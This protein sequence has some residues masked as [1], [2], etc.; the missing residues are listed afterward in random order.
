MIVF[1]MH[2]TYLD[3]ADFKLHIAKKPKRGTLLRLR[4][5]TSE[6]SSLSRTPLPCR[7]IQSAILHIES[8]F[9]SNK[10]P[11]PLRPCDDKSSSCLHGLRRIY[12][13]SDVHGHLSLLLNFL[14]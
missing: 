11:T 1:W 8:L 7:A 3:A 14:I 4:L 12:A 9:S 6:G 2:S 10:F 5:H 13:L